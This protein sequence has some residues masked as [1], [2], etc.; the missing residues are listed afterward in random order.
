MHEVFNNIS[1]YYFSLL[2]M[3]VFYMAVI[4]LE[5]MATMENRPARFVNSTKIDGKI[6]KQLPSNYIMSITS[7]GSKR[8]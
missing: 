1:Y 5:A 4:L 7:K 3:S 2:L 6:N 8:K